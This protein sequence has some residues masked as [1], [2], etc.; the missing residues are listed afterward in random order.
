MSAA[1][2]TDRSS[3]MAAILAAMPGTD[4]FTQRQR[5]LTA[6]QKLGSVTSFEASR[7]LDCYHPPARVFELRKDG[8]KI[9][10][11]MRPERTESGKVHHVGVYLMSG[12]AH[13]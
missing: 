8:H 5:M 13:V 2:S 10:T 3:V 4:A 11:V 12:G 9:T 1:W 6:I 7:Y